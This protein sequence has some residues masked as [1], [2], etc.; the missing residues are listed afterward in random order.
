MTKRSPVT[1][2][3]NDGR[4]DGFRRWTVYVGNVAAFDIEAT[5]VDSGRPRYRTAIVHVAD[6]FGKSLARYDGRKDT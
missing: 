5:F 1:V 4:R 3:R 6:R 2:V